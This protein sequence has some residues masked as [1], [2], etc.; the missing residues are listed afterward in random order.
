MGIKDSRVSE[1]EEVE[2]RVV[3]A[4]VDQR[5]AEHPAAH[6]QQAEPS[7]DQNHVSEQRSAAALRH[8]DK[9]AERHRWGL[10]PAGAVCT[11]VCRLFFSE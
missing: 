4:E 5:P 6:G 3:L 11:N 8:L 7:C 2:H 10:I 9:T 1:E